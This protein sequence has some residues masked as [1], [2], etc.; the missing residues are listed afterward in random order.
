[1]NQISRRELAEVIVDLLDKGMPLNKVARETAA[2]LLTENRT[3]E[4]APLMRDVMDLRTRSGVVEA[5]AVS[6]HSLNDGVKRELKR[7]VAAEYGD[8]RRV[9]LNE[10]RDPAVIGGV[11]I[12][13]GELQLD[14]SVQGKLRHLTGLQPERG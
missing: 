13:A 10:E 4:L 1:M 14:L 9:L 7:L 8:T 11:K 5:T 2:Y 3:P 6:V 12:M